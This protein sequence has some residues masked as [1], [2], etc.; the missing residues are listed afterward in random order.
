MKGG[1]LLINTDIKDKVDIQ[2]DEVETIVASIV[3]PYT[4]DLTIHI[5][6]LKSMAIQQGFT[7]MSISEL[8]K[9]LLFISTSLYSLAGNMEKTAL[10]QAVAATIKNNKYNEFYSKLSEGTISDKKALSESHVLDEQLVEFV[11]KSAYNRLKNLFE[12]GNEIHSALKKI[13][14]LKNSEM[15]LSMKVN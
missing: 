15:Q 4:G 10:R 2:S 1:I 5:N 9:S 3:R 6:N 12:A 11:Y 13:V 8:T 7:D 14:N